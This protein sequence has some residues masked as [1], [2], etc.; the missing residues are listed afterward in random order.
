[1]HSVA[2]LVIGNL[3]RQFADELGTLG[4]RTYQAHLAL[5]DVEQLRQF[6][7]T[8]LAQPLARARDAIVIHRRPARLAVA[9]GI[10]AHAAELGEQED[11]AMAADAMLPVEH[12]R[13]P[14]PLQLDGERTAQHQRQR[15]QED[16]TAGEEIEEAFQHAPRQRVAETAA[17]QPPAWIDERSE[18]H[19][20]ELQSRDN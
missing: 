14:A 1:M 11:P 8:Q 2:A 5:D 13:T 15:Q 7:E 17:E 12:A 9:L 18:A 16:E 20:P 3:L 19:T 10:L 6:V 4:T